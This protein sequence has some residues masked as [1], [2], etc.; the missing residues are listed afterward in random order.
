MK[1]TNLGKELFLRSTKILNIG[2]ATVAYFLIALFTLFVLEKMYGKFD[3]KIYEK[4]K[5]SELIYDLII[6]LWIIGIATY[7]VRNLFVL[8]PFPL[9]GI[10]GYDHKKVKEV[11]NA[12]VFSIFIISLNPRIQGY[13]SILRNRLRENIN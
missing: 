2:W 1:M 11:T 6:Y 7:I 5:T 10:M 9:D 12:T 3:E 13:Y 8:F 4:L